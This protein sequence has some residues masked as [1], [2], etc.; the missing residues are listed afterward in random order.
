MSIDD[1]FSQAAIEGDLPV[2]RRISTSVQLQS[3]DD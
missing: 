3:I 1:A 2:D